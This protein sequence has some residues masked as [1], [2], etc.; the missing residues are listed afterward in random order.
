MNENDRFTEVL[1]YLIGSKKVRNQQEFTDRIGSNKSTVSQIKNGET[2]IPN[3]LFE[4]ITTAFPI[5]SFDWLKKGEGEMLKNNQQIG[6]ISN[7]TVVG[8]DING[9]GI[10][11]SHNDFA[12]IIEGYQEV[13][14]KNQEQIDKLIEIIKEVTSHDK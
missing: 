8:A 6:N 5:I 12:G 10:T 9:N 11:I 1:N 4:K 7:S 13:I 3:N 14:K 2:K